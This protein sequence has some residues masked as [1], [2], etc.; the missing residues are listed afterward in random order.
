MLKLLCSALLL[1][2][3]TTYGFSISPLSPGMQSKLREAKI[4]TPKCPVPLTRLKRIQVSYYDL[5]GKVHNDGNLIALDAV[6]PTLL[7]LFEKLYKEKFRIRMINPI[8][9]FEGKTEAARDAGDT[10]AFVCNPNANNHIAPIHRY[11]VAV[12]INPAQNPMITFPNTSKG[13]AQISP[14][15]GVAYV[16]RYQ[17][18]PGMNEPIV[19]YFKKYGFPIWLGE[20]I[21]PIRYQH[22]QTSE[23]VAALLTKMDASDAKVLF[24]I[25]DQKGALVQKLSMENLPAILKLYQFDRRQFLNVFQ[26]QLYYLKNHSTA[27]FMARMEKGILRK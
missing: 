24:K 18:R 16:N 6:A 10:F 13:V 14:A 20:H 26:H 11:G 8:Q 7:T 25:V 27:E 5:D 9:R 15:E 12:D 17:Q 22:F 23:F 4:W 2:A 21:A 3:T 19:K 1:I